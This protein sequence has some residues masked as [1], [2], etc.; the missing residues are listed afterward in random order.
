[1][2][3]DAEPVEV[4]PIAN[5]YLALPEEEQLRILEEIERGDPLAKEEARAA[6]LAHVEGEAVRN[7]LRRN[8]R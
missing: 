6:A 4:A 7:R 5:A 8:R 3:E 2:P 1:M